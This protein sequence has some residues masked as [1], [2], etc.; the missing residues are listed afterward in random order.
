MTHETC[1]DRET[2]ENLLL[3]KLTGP[4]HESLEE[5]FLTCEKC[6]SKIE[7]LSGSDE[8]T[9]AIRRRRVVEGQDS[10]LNDVIEKAKQIR[11]P[12]ETIAEAISADQDTQSQPASLSQT[13]NLQELSFLNPAEEPD[14]I[15]RLGGYR[16]LDVLGTGGMGVVFRAEDPKLNRPVA[17]KVMKPFRR[18]GRGCQGAVSQGSPSH[19]RD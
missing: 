17:L 19:R 6:A 4:N 14:E 9:E 3:G 18:F 12:Q 2:L 10:A 11:P 13:T 7:T 8:L 1:P 15:G 5:H 16:V